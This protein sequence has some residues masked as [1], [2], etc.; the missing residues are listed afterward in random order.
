[1]NNIRKKF[2]SRIDEATAFASLL[3]QFGED[4][5][6]GEKGKSGEF[7]FAIKIGCSTLYVMIY[8]A[9]EIT[10]KMCIEKI[11]K[12]IEM[13]SV[14]ITNLSEYWRAEYLKRNYLKRLQEGTN[15][16]Q[17]LDLIADDIL[18]TC[19]NI[20]F[21]NE[22]RR[23][24]TNIGAAMLSSMAKKLNL[25]YDP[26][27]L[28]CATDLETIRSRRNSLSHGDESFAEAGEV[29]SADDILDMIPR[30]KASIHQF[31]NAIEEYIENIGYKIVQ[32]S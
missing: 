30:I 26:G 18:K 1:M 7:R 28:S 9:I 23:K 4:A 27:K 5:T 19:E 21:S 29:L 2:D 6:F 24:N 32:D 22:S 3:K 13:S 15:N 17:I 31:L 14:G 12:E 10:F 20:K 11:E 16:A 25:N 8:S